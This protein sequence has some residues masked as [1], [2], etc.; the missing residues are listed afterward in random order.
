MRAFYHETRG[1]WVTTG[2][3]IPPEILAEYPEGTVETPLQ[4]GPDHTWNGTEW[5]YTA[6]PPPPPAD[7]S[8][9]QFEWLLAFTGLGDVWDALQ[10]TLKDTDRATYAAI[11]M[12]RQRTLYRLSVT[13]A[14]VAKMRPLA[15]QIAPDVDLSDAAILAAWEL[16]EAME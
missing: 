8:R 9:A 16:A 5:V 14:E 11:K 10:S 3:D 13:L 12:E 6:P 4:P 15:A 1:N 7:L 2:D